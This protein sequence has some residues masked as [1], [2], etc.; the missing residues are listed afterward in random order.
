M[1]VNSVIIILREVL[2]AALIISVLLAI[3]QQLKVSR[4]WLFFALFIGLTGASVYAAHIEFVSM[5]WR[6]L[7]KK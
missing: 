1:L 4:Q 2:E 5:E 3:S 7:V 6:V